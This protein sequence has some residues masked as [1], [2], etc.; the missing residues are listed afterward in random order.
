MRDS[1][2]IAL[3][4]ALLPS[5]AFDTVNLNNSGIQL[6]T[7]RKEMLQDAI[8]TMKQVAALG[9]KQIESARS[10]KGNYY[11]LK[12]SE[13]KQLCKDLDLTLRSGHVHIDDQWQQTM[14][15]AAEAGQ[16]YIICSS[17]PSKG[18]TTDNYKR[19]AE[20]FNKSGAECKKL[21]LKFGYHNHDYEF[22]NENGKILYDVLVENTDKSLVNMELDLG[23][24]IA[25][26]KD[27]IHYFKQFPGRFPLWH[28][29]DMDLVKKNS[30]E[31]GKGSLDIKKMLSNSDKS[32]MK[33]F[34]V[35]Q[36]EYSSSPFESMKYNLDYLKKIKL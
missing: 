29:K 15:D 1:T 11:G 3:G 9:F 17:M 26:G 4:T 31:F 25:A 24:V 30:T 7:V 18:Q 19:A 33:Y 8:G 28:L 35:E 20:S 34:F 23:W 2:A 14:N 6:Y 36:E 16:E 21:N 22:E 12:P 32:G 10:D 13:I 27:P 5:F